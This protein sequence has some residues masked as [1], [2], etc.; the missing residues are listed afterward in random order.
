MPRKYFLSA[1]FTL[2]LLVVVASLLARTFQPRVTL[3]DARESFRAGKFERAEEQALNVSQNFSGMREEALLLAIK[4]ASAQ[5]HYQRAW[6]Y[7]E[8]LLK[9]PQEFSAEYGSMA[10]EF[11]F[12]AGQLHRSISHFERLVQEFPEVAEF[13]KRLIY[14]YGMTGRNFDAREHLR[15]LVD[16]GLHDLNILLVLGAPNQVVNFD[17]ALKD[18]QNQNPND[19][20]LQLA[21]GR[22]AL[23]NQQN[24]IAKDHLLRAVALLPTSVEAY[25]SLGQVESELRDPEGVKRWIKKNLEGQ[26]P[27][28]MFWITLGKWA[29]EF[30]EYDV[31]LDCF[32]RAS[33]LDH[34]HESVY[35]LLAE[36]YGRRG[37]LERAKLAMDRHAKINNFVRLCLE[38]YTRQPDA[39]TIIDAANRCKELGRTKEADAWAS[40]IQ[41][42]YGEPNP[43]LMQ[44][45]AALRKTLNG[46]PLVWNSL[47][48]PLDLPSADGDVEITLIA[49]ML[50]LRISETPGVDSQEIRF[51]NVAPTAGLNFS[52]F[53]SPK[54]GAESK[55]LYEFAGGGVGV[56]DFDR[57]GWPDVVLSQGCHWPPDEIPAKRHRRVPKGADAGLSTEEPLTQ[58]LF[59]NQQGKS[60]IDISEASGINYSAYGQGVA[61]GDVNND[62][63]DDIYIATIGRNILLL[64]NG[65]GTFDDVTVE[66]G[67]VDQSWTTSCAIADMDTD[68]YADI[69]DVNYLQ[70]EDLF[71]REC[72]WEG[73]RIRICG[74]GTFEASSDKLWINNR[75]QFME[76][77]REMG[78]SASDGKGL[79]I[80]VG[81]FLQP[82]TNC[83]FIANDQTANHFFSRVPIEEWPLN[84]TDSMPKANMSFRNIADLVGLSMDSNGAKQGCMGIAVGDFDA[85]GSLDFFVTNYVTESNTL[86]SQINPARFEDRTRRAMLSEPS[87]AMVGFGTQAVDPLLDGNIDLVVTN[88]HLDRFDFKNQLYQMPPQYFRNDSRG[89]FQ[90]ASKSWQGY[91][92]GRYLGRAMAKVDWNRDGKEDLLISHLDSPVALLENQSSTVYQSISLRLVGTISS[93][94]AIGTQVKIVDNQKEQIQILSAGNG[95]QCCNEKRIIFG[96]GATKKVPILEI[97]WIGGVVERFEGV[98][99]GNWIAIEGIGLFSESPK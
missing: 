73:N 58:V 95:Y 69:Y 89:V 30:E 90:E 86:Y 14:L 19:P 98:E 54:P 28:P 43:Q 49:S 4:S 50:D 91:W 27:H 59:R 99:V 96:T 38:M 56:L 71:T 18:I 46:N 1:F 93:R 67:I 47:P 34:N 26:I 24:E 6:M 32:I 61:C 22:V 88:G 31:A 7:S 2:T 48:K 8:E 75:S 5:T 3:R 92:A 20:S 83:I 9:P 66:Y 13:R 68:G 39:R 81:S 52:Y 77:S 53:S 74:P 63:F 45:A 97:S 87:F 41:R 94:D 62:G 11:A 33:R 78:V 12:R 76:Q 57:D 15:W 36:E 60:F 51:S 21:L 64:N 85:N 40:L 70:G 42:G 72:R 23:A 44:A 35:F 17:E 10:G 82:Q 84:A 25:V 79:G 80:V 65:D 37:E 29:K 55:Q 16:R